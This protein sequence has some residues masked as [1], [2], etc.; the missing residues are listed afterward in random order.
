MISYTK[1]AASSDTDDD[2]GHLINRFMQSIYLAFFTS[3]LNRQVKPIVEY[4]S[5]PS[6]SFI[7][8]SGNSELDTPPRFMFL[9][10]RKNP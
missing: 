4:L 9:E 1:M 8:R 2:D 3:L 10:L 7:N 5:F 6:C